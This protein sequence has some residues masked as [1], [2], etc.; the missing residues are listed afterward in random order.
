MI[1]DL[2]NMYG[3]FYLNKDNKNHNLCFFR[4]KET[5]KLKKESVVIPIFDIDKIRNFSD[6]IKKEMKNVVETK[7]IKPYQIFFRKIQD[8]LELAK[9]S[10]ELNLSSEEINNS[11]VKFSN[12]DLLMDSILGVNPKIKVTKRPRKEYDKDRFNLN[13][14]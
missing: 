13:K 11:L 9:V 14:L 8:D 7:F 1:K 6:S 2:R 12:I 4:I 5:N 3:I 10:K